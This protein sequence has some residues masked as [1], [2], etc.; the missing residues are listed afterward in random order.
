MFLMYMHMHIR[1]CSIRSLLYE[2]AWSSRLRDT[3]L[4]HSVSLYLGM[5]MYVG[6]G[7]CI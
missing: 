6:C 3:D 4:T 7:R 5:S 1:I 2:A